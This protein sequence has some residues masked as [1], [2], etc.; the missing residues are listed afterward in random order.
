MQAQ[1]LDMISSRFGGYL[2]YAR[3]CRLTVSESG[4]KLGDVPRRNGPTL[5]P[6]IIAYVAGIFLPD[7]DP[8]WCPLSH[9]L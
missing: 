6:G 9:V 5:T 2:G 4:V 3:D 8:S 1:P 7:L